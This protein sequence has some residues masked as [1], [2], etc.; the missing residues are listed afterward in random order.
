MK[1][2]LLL[3]VLAMMMAFTGADGTDLTG[4]EGYMLMQKGVTLVYSDY[5]GKE[6]LT[7][8]QTNTV[9]EITSE[10]GILKVTMHTISKDA[11]DKVLSEGD[12][13][14]TCENGVI[15]IDMKSMT[16]QGMYDSM[17]GMEIGIDQTDLVFPATFKEGQTLEDGQMTMTISSGGMQVMKMVTNIT[18]RNVEKFENLTTPAGSFDCVK[19]NQVMSTEMMGRTTKMKSIQWLSLNVG[20]VRT[21]TYNEDGTLQSV[22]LLTQIIK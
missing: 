12:F 20:A 18:D 11:K 4:C 15:K 14:F 6:K 19:M 10:G 16:G 8:T 3:P 2:L 17:E 22:H 5:D 7:G 9:K 21:E 1:K 13:S